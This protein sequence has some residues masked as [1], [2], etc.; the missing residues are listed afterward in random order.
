MTHNARFGSRSR[1]GSGWGR[2]ALVG[3]CGLTLSLG[4]LGGCASGEQYSN[5]R[6]EARALQDQNTRLQSDLNRT[7]S[8]LAIER[9]QRE[10][11]EATNARLRQ[12]NQQ[13]EGVVAQAEKD[14]DQFQGRLDN[15][16]MVDPR[17]ERALAR[18][19]D[20]HPALQWDQQARVLRFSSDLTF[21]SG[22]DQIKE[23]AKGSLQAL[24]TLLQSQD[25]NRYEI[26]I[27]GHTDAAPIS[28]ATAQRHPTNM[29]LSCHRAI[30]VRK[31]L[32]SLGVPS[33]RMMA[34]GWGE[35]HPIVPNGPR[36]VAAQNRRVEIMLKPPAQ[37]GY[38]TH[39]E[40]SLDPMDDLPSRDINK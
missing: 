20:Q 6:N 14:F 9:E 16:Q 26:Q 15:L 1:W 27:I 28:S 37:T 22:S 31:E 33:E 25:A 18:L 35:T 39:N 24:A 30:S 12:T 4:T 32:S 29:H 13:L 2:A 38:A 21:D 10:K 7:N 40:P 8:E 19:A 34:A 3:A 17:T 36:G 11:L 23:T 5:A